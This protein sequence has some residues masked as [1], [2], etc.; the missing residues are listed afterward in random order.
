MEMIVLFP[1]FSFAEKEYNCFCY[2]GYFLKSTCLASAKNPFKVT[3]LK[4]RMQVNASQTTVNT[5]Y[6]QWTLNI[7]C[8]HRLPSIF[9]PL[10]CETH[11]SPQHML[12][13]LNARHN[14]CKRF[15]CVRKWADRQR[16]I[17]AFSQSRPTPCMLHIL[18]RSDFPLGFTSVYSQ[19]QEY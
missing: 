1:C 11:T 3:H 16:Q 9:K 5:N 12:L 4:W 6:T 7:L 2:W 19:Q 14:E 15:L 18:S 13:C 8:N 17:L 10:N